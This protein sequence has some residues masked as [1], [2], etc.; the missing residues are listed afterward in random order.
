MINEYLFFRFFVLLHR[1]GI[2]ALRIFIFVMAIAD[3]A[4]ADDRFCACNA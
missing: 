3:T 1:R 4:S 2:A